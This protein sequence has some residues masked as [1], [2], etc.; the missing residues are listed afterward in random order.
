MTI[1]IPFVRFYKTTFVVGLFVWFWSLCFF[2]CTFCWS[3]VAAFI[4]PFH[5]EITSRKVKLYFMSFSKG[6]NRSLRAFFP[7]VDIPVCLYWLLCRGYFQAGLSVMAFSKYRRL[8]TEFEYSRD[9]L[10]GDTYS[11]PYASFPTSQD[12]GD[13]YQT[14]P[15]S[16]PPADSAPVEDTNGD[17]FKAP[18]YW[19][20]GEFSFVCISSAW[21]T[22]K[23]QNCRLPIHCR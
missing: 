9:N 21:F 23:L 16:E 8:L 10:S 13:P 11:S 12:Q 2:S 1:H 20:S 7:V 5:P 6:V 14:K 18:P 17:N 22:S 19:V 15:F 4:Q 3:P